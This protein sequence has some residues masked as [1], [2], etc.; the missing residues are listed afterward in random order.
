M[1]LSDHGFDGRHKGLHRL[2]ASAILLCSMQAWCDV[3]VVGGEDGYKP[4]E[5]LDSSGQA[6]G[7]NV[8]LMKAIA[9]EAGFEARFHLGAWKEVRTALLNGDV[10]V[11]GMFVSDERAETVDFAKPHVI[12]NH[13]IFV[14]VNA[15]TIHSIQDLA[16]KRVIVQR[17]AFSHEQLL[18]IGIDAD[19]V[20]VDT[21]A[22]GLQ[23]L[24]EG[25]HD[26]ALLTEH[27][28]RFTM[29]SDNLDQ[30]TVSGPPVL[31][32]TYA[33]AVPK[34]KEVMLETLNRGLER[35]MASGEFDRIYD[36]W[37][38][39]YDGDPASTISPGILIAVAVLIVLLVAVTAWQTRRILNM[40]TEQ[41]E[42][43]RQLDFLK[44][45][46]ALTG[47]MNRLAFENELSQFLERCDGK[48][49]HV[50][51]VV[52]VDQFRLVNENLGHA[53]GDRM[54][55]ELARRLVEVF[56]TQA[57]IGRL[58]SD[59]F[60]V[61][62]PH[63]SSTD[64]LEQGEYLLSVLDEL[65]LRPG[66]KLG[67]SIGLVPFDGIG[68]TV[69]QLLRRADCA[70]LAAKEDGG[71]RVHCWHDDD[72]RLAER[73]GMLR[74][75]AQIQS[76]MHEQRL[77]FYYQP[78]VAARGADN[79]IHAVEVLVR[80]CTPE[81]EVLPA[82]VFMPA[83]ER[84]YLSPDIDRWMVQ[85]VLS[86]MKANP[87]VL[88][89]LERIN[90]NLS[91][92]SLGDDRFLE[93][94]MV[95]VER[96][97]DMVQKLCF[98]ITETALIAN[99]DTARRALTDLHRKGCRFAL[100][101]FGSGLSSMAYLKNLPVDYL[102]I[103]GGFVRD[104]EQDGTALEMVQEINR[105]GHAVGKLTIA[106]FVESSRIRDL[107]TESGIDLLQGYDIGRPAPMEEL[108][109]WCRDR[110]VGASAVKH[111]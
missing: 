15:S 58:G 87:E 84:Y 77:L 10:D 53:G 21:D 98:E 28:G 91:G 23:L 57:R 101:D 8:D 95:T 39:P 70:G 102:K 17:A 82:G 65:E 40:R 27:R 51:L 26:A 25:E 9:R 24:A 34:G 64:A 88:D 71:N 108:L 107:L 99:L 55:I 97:S 11:L 14:P 47:L 19:L 31:P 92:R 3:V 45:H 63:T 13:R 80:M 85:S 49:E 4:Y 76:A 106:E 90:I 33:F 109:A 74:W 20:L 62:M 72:R 36:R 86:W 54:L 96:H 50:L 30:L 37:L 38:Q 103:D 93:F 60:V 61:L 81:G 6:V 1:R 83:A 7:F 69:A 68:N 111:G 67:V 104:I 79:K 41:R 29:R 75:V 32:V 12:V 78:I 73:V 22:E 46:D 44:S 89:C 43:D 52:D 18:Q 56:A 94:L 105:L 16:G 48:S 59:E 2:F 100:D 110:N 5:T 66:M 35:V 42:A